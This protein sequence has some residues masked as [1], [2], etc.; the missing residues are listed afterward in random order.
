MKKT[1]KTK[2]VKALR[3]GKYMQAEGQLKDADGGF[4][5]LGVLTDICRKESKS[6]KGWNSFISKCHWNKVSYDNDGFDDI[7]PDEVMKWAG[8]HSHNPTIRGLTL[9]LRNDSEE[10]DFNKIANLIEKNL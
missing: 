9:S 6:K 7:L 2:W 3:S 8:L 1:I 10:E 5:C 4:C